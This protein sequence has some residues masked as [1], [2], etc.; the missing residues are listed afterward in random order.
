MKTD[1]KY[2]N[3]WK[4]EIFFMTKTVLSII[5]ALAIKILF[6]L[7]KIYSNYTISA[8]YGKYVKYQGR[9]GKMFIVRRCMT[10]KNK[11]N[12]AGDGSANE[13]KTE[14]QWSRLRR[15]IP[16]NVWWWGREL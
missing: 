2:R 16:E 13:G 8:F 12:L 10:N 1:C 6:L 14:K 5:C 9:T 7:L 3:F 11:E 4:P 15:E